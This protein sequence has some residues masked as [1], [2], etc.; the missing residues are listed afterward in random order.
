MR[1]GQRLGL[2][3]G[4]ILF[5]MIGIVVFISLSLNR[6][7]KTQKIAT[8]HTSN[9]KTIDELQEHIE[10]WL[11]TV[12]EIV[13]KR[14]VSHLDYHE[15]LEASIEKE[16][17][18]VD[19]TIYDE[20]GNSLLNEIVHIFNGIKKLDT[21]LQL[22]LRMGNNP[23]ETIKTSEAIKIFEE[24]ASR[25][26]KVL[27]E[28]NEMVAI[29]HKRTISYS[30]RV[31]KNCWLSIYIVAPI[32][33]VFGAIY[34]YLTTRGVIK[35][36]NLLR[37]ATK[38]IAS[39]SFDTKLKIKSSTEIEELSHAF[40]T[41]VLKL[42]ESNI[43]LA[44]SY[45]TI[46]EQKDFFDTILSNTKD[47]ILVINKENKIEYMNNAASKEY[48]FALGKYCYH[49]ICNQEVLCKQSGLKEVLKGQALKT[50]RTINGRVYDSIVVPF[51]TGDKNISKMEILRDITERKHLQ[52]ELE[53]LSITDKLTGLY[54]RRYFDDVLEKEVLRARR[55]RH[56]LS[57]LFIDIDKFKHFNDTYGHA[58]GDK[59]LQRLGNLIKE[60]VRKGVDIPCRYGGEEFTIILPET[61]NSNAVTI[62]NRILKDFG[63]MKFYVSSKDEMVQKTVSIGIAEL[64]SHNN[65][66]AKTLLV[67]ADETMYRAKKLGGN[68]VCEYEFEVCLKSIDSFAF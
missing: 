58:M 42:S 31:E 23:S 49:A 67:N 43:K 12:E 4:I 8:I 57:L 11:I 37:T 20:R 48:G 64:N 63:D 22:S 66:N 16:I 13:K 21:A 5:L 24:D 19:L 61:T 44:K 45:K 2:G 39:G 52:N 10:H 46:K 59:V 51:V 29:P 14:D 15:I 53:R 1:V 68:R 7:G 62:A 17:K 35:P 38:R 28:L 60:Q 30:K 33:V 32:A 41:M 27:A 40:N 47:L 50:E 25:L 9:L 34:A 6:I 54:N 55:L 56:N 18:G 36:L 3:F 26:N 65:D